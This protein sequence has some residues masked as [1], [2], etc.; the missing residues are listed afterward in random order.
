L[1]NPSPTPPEG[2]GIVLP[3]L[4]NFE[5]LAGWFTGESDFY[6]MEFLE[7]GYH[8]VAKVITGDAPIYSI[9]EQYFDTIRVEV[10]VM[11]ADGPD[12]TYFGVVCRFVDASNLYRFVVD[13]DGYYEI[14]KKVNGEFTVINSGSGRNIFLINKPNHIQVDCGAKDTTVN[15]DHR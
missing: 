9:R 2:A 6:L 3:Y 7:G 1:V 11:R 8:M 10:D 14:A 5:L 13:V 15:G 4:D 12:G